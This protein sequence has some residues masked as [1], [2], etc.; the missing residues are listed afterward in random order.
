MNTKRL[1]AEVC[2]LVALRQLK[3]SALVSHTKIW[4]V[5]YFKIHSE[6]SRVKQFQQ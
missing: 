1:F 4:N 5:I 2:S 6:F 3:R